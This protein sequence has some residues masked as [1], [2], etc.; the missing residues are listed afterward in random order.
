[1]AATSN[2]VLNQ[3][4]FAMGYDSVPVT[5]QNP[6]FD[7][8]KGGQA[9]AR[10]YQPVVSAVLRRFA[11]DF[12]RMFA[13]L[14]LSGNTAPFPWTYEYV[15]PSNAIQVLQLAPPSLIDA[16]DPRP[17]EW[18]VGNAIVGA[19]INAVASRVIWSN[20][21]TASVVFTGYAAESTWDALFRQTVVSLLSSVLAFSLA[22]KPEAAEAMIQ[23]Y[24]LFGKD[25]EGRDS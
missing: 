5:G 8:S 25:A 18:I 23:S 16:N 7:S 1:V 22:G 2:D 6:T 9:G 4:L 19:G 10:F 21:K 15:Y 11:S 24:M 14:T 12:S 3:A 17:I 20:L 13:A